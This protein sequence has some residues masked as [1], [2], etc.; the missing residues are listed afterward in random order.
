MKITSIMIEGGSEISGSVVKEK[1]CDK[2]IYFIAP[3]II[4]GRNSL[5][6][7]GGEGVK[8]LK[9]FMEIKNMSVDKLGDDL[10]IEGSLS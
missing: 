8:Y 9:D 2:V 10:V 5:S 1:L 4:G 6:P 3:K 7:V